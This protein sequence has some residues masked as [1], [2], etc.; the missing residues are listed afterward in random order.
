M[1]HH[2]VL[3]RLRPEAKRAGRIESLPELERS[4]QAMRGAIPGLLR[5]QLGVNQADSPD[6]VDLMLYTEFATWE[7]LRGY[8][9]HPLHDELRKLLGPLRIE[10][11]V[12]D[13]EG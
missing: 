5:A 2:V 7:A 4:V 3:W 9:R 11:R 13:Y 6:A 8:E 10:R 1:I 12:V